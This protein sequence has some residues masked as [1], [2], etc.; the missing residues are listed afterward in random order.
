MVTFLITSLFILGFLGLVIYFWQKP[1]PQID[2]EFLLPQTGNRGLFADAPLQTDEEKQLAAAQLHNEIRRAARS[3]EINALDIAASLKDP[4]FYSEVVEL[5]LHEA[6]DSKVLSIASHISRNNLIVTTALA[7]KFR[8]LWLSKPDRQSTA[9]MLHLTA[10][11]NDASA[12]SSAVE[13]V[14]QLRRKGMLDDV[15]NEELQSLILS[16]YWLLS[17]TTRNSGAGFVLKQTI[18]NAKHDLAQPNN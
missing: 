1:A 17:S 3:G 18:A 15:S 11:A 12:F 14:V 7:E 10:L 4:E 6:Q 16:E 5:L 9:K 8:Q 13:A 2:T